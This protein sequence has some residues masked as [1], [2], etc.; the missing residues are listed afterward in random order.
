VLNKPGVSE[1]IG[2]DDQGMEY[3]PM[4]EKESNLRKKLLDR[5]GKEDDHSR[6]DET[7]DRDDRDRDHPRGRPRDDR[8]H[9]HRDSDRQRD[10]D[11]DRSRDR[12]TQRGYDDRN[13]RDREGRY[14]AERSR[15]GVPHQAN[16]SGGGGKWDVAGSGDAKDG[17]QSPPRKRERT[18]YEGGRGGRKEGAGGKFI[19]KDPNTPLCAKLA[20]RKETDWAILPVLHYRKKIVEMIKN[21]KV[22]YM[23]C[24]CF[25][26]VG[27]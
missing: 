14:G 20:E 21:N 8:D 2:M 9:Q 25:V 6:R 7:R 3:D 18:A 16:R 24:M 23:R 15:D 12:G 17:A 1:L 13:D 5:L 27:W 26:G 4:E 19:V 10:R 11:R 22:I